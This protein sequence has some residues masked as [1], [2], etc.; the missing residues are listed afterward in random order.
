MNHWMWAVSLAGFLS[1]AE[2]TRALWRAVPEQSMHRQRCFDE[3]T[4]LRQFAPDQDQ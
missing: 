3:A 1:T 2:R 4:A